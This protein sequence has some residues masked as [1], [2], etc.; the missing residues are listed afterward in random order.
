M[1]TQPDLLSRIRWQTLQ[2]QIDQWQNQRRIVRLNRQVAIH[3]CSGGQSQTTVA[4]F[5]ASARLTGFTLNAAFTLLTSWSLRLSGVQV[6]H[7]VCQAGMSQCVLGTNSNHLDQPPPCQKCV[8]LSNQLYTY[9]DLNWFTYQEEPTLKAALEDLNIAQLSRFEYPFA[10][11]DPQ[12]SRGGLLQIP[13]GRLVVPSARWALRRHTL[14]DDAP[15][16]ALLRRYILS[17]YTIAVQ[18][19][20]FLDAEKI[21]LAV[22]FNG[23]LYPEAAARWVSR[24]IGVRSVAFEVGFQPFSVFFTDGEPTAYPIG[25]PDSFELSSEQNARLDNLLEKRFQGKFTMAGIRFW[26][27]MRGLGE[28]LLEKM[29]HFKQVVPVFT[30][31]VYDTSQVHANTLFDNMF[32]WLDM[33][34]EII[35]CHPETLFVIRAHPDEKR[36]VSNKISN[37]SVHDWIYRNQVHLF[38]NVFF[39]EPDEFLSSYELIQ[40]SKFV[41][42]YNSSIGLEATL[43]GAPVICGGN[44][45]Y[46]QYPT[47]FLPE[48]AEALGQMIEEFLEVEQVTEIFTPEIQQ[49]FQRNARRFLYYQFYKISLPLSDYLQEGEKQGF[50][51]LKTFPWQKLLPENSPLLKLICE[52]LLHQKPFLLPESEIK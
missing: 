9:A 21:K 43:L 40:R 10:L 3:E 23:A 18:F 33:I 14:M 24:K 48:S 6:K 16:R 1:P 13:L 20:E 25:I 37:E 29:A 41:L 12:V 34:L 22:I 38:P 26:P 49:A 7:F 11:H 31:V 28:D 51:Y 15:T 46:T 32:A 17:A 42:V 8:D 2:R 50:V 52:G 45:R 36:P 5:V 30:N 4:F 39:I 27:E 47:V 44:A 35:R 19:A